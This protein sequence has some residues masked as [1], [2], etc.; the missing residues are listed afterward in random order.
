MLITL[1]LIMAASGT[2][3][4]G[5][6][7]DRSVADYDY[8]VAPRCVAHPCTVTINYPYDAVGT[9]D[10][11]PGTWGTAG[12]DDGRIDFKVPTGF[13]VRILRVYGNFTARMRGTVPEGQYAG[14]LFGLLKT[15]SAPS[16]LATF[17]STNC[18]LY[19]QADVGSVPAHVEFDTR[20][21][22]GV[23]DD[24]VLWIRRAV[25][26]N[27]TGISIHEEPSFVVVFQWE[28]R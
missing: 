4:V 6:E 13:K 5:G 24:G 9:P 17:S 15:G 22:D 18:L 16:D 1:A 20:V 2:G 25:Y 14:A 26:L 3:T 21:D 28:K 19:V 8:L 7:S 10:A 27:E 11:R 23:L 12:F